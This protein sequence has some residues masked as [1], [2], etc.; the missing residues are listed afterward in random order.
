[1][2]VNAGMEWVLVATFCAATPLVVALYLRLASRHDVHTLHQ[3]KAAA[4]STDGMVNSSTAESSAMLAEG[5]SRHG[6]ED[7][8]EMREAGASN[9]DSKRKK[10]M[11]G[12]RGHWLLGSLPEVAQLGTHH[13]HVHWAQ[14]FGKVFQYRMGFQQVVVVA[15]P[16]LASDVLVKQ[17]QLFHDRP[18][19]PVVALTEHGLIL[20]RC[21]NAL[22][23]GLYMPV[24]NAWTLALLK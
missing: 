23:S 2:E 4:G 5:G 18:M 1:M 10:K 9:N 21:T 19:Q 8:S 14:Q 20:G 11:P 16:V 6:H 22:L 17:F 3:K 24:T 15:D 13:C 12:P 7:G